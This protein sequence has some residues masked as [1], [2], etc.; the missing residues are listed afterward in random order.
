MGNR[1]RRKGNVPPGGATRRRYKGE[2]LTGH[3]IVCDKKIKTGTPMDAIMSW[4]IA[5]GGVMFHSDGNFG[6]TTYDNID[7]REY[8]QIFV[9]DECM[10]KKAKKIWR[11]KT[12]R[13][14]PEDAEF[15]TFDVEP[16]WLRGAPSETQRI[17]QEAY[18][19]SIRRK[20]SKR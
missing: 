20:S 7:E 2:N 12:V 19:N 15:T 6:S 9:C 11:V 1:R 3:C 17:V 14:P 10:K 4:G 8:V 18:R 13:H 16:E 5:W